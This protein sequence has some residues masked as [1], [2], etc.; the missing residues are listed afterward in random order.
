MPKIL[1]RIETSLTKQKRPTSGK[2]IFIS[3]EGQVTEEEY[4]KI[5]SNMFSGIKSKIQFISVMEDILSIPE[6]SRTPE[7]VHEL[8]KSKPWQLVEKI[9][10][11]KENEK[12]RYDFA[13]HPEDEFWIISDVDDNTSPINIDKWNQMLQDC[14]S[15]QYGLA[16]SNP[17]FE[18][19]LLLHH[20]DAN[21]ED[22]KYAV[23]NAHSYERTSHYRDRLRDDANAP[24]K[25]QKHILTEHYSIEKVKNAINRAKVL[26]KEET[27]EW[28]TNLG[29]TVFVL[30]D[31]IIEISDSITN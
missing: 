22:F 25:K 18:I 26:H 5:I 10:K 16:I 14:L 8:T 30:L 13:H 1:N 23:N 3:C 6:R 9:D 27:Q 29:S 4:F 31:K 2:I 21:D 28:P 19:W 7:Q 12:N 17:F 24:L 20:V 15:K 11:F